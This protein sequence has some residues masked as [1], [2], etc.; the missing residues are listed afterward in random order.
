[1]KNGLILIMFQIAAFILNLKVKTLK[2]NSIIF[3]EIQLAQEIFLC[4]I[5]NNLPYKLIIIGYQKIQLRAHCT[6][7]IKKKF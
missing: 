3:E 4:L 1:M 5:L 6:N 2:N 7:D